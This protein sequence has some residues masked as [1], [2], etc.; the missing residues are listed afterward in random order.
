MNELYVKIIFYIVLLFLGN[1]CF[2]ADRSND[3]VDGEAG[4]V[5]AGVS[6]VTLYQGSM[7][8]Q[9]PNKDSDKDGLS[10]VRESWWL[11]DP[12]DNDTNDDG[13]LDGDSVDFFSE[14]KT[15]PYKDENLKYN[16]VDNDRLPN[17]AEMYDTGTHYR[18][19][20]TDGDP[21][22]DG[23]E[24][25]NMNMPEISPA[26]HP[27]VA[28]YPHLSVRLT[29][30]NVVPKKEIVSTTGGS[31][32]DA[33]SISTES[34]HS[35][36][37]SFEFGFEETVS[38]EYEFGLEGG[39]TIGG[40]FSA[41]QI[42]E[43]GDTWT[44]TKTKSNSG[45]NQEDWST[46]TTTSTTDAA[47]LG[48]GL[49]VQNSGTIPAY[50]VKPDINIKL[51]NKVI[52]TVTL[53]PEIGSI[54]IG[55]ESKEFF[56]D[57]KLVGQ[58]PEEIT[59][60]ME[61][62]RFI[63]AGTPLSIET[64]QVRADVLQWDDSNNRWY[65]MDSSSYINEID[66]R[67][68]TL[69]FELVD[70]DYKEYKVFTAENS[71]MTLGDA[72][73]LTI[74]RDEATQGMNRTWVFGFSEGALREARK[75]L[76]GNESIYNLKLEPGWEI[77]IK[78]K[79][80]NP[81]P[82]I[83]W[84][85]YSQDMKTIFA[86]VTDDLKVKSVAAHV[87]MGG[88]FKDLNMTDYDGDTIYT[89][90]S[91][92]VLKVDAGNYV[93]ATDIENNSA[94]SYI[95][96]SA[97]PDVVTPNQAWHQDIREIQDWAERS[98]GFGS[99]LT[100]GDFDGDGFDDLAV[101]VP[102]DEAVQII[103]GSADGLA[104]KNSTILYLK[105]M[106]YF[107]DSPYSNIITAGGDFDGNGID[108]LAIGEFGFILYDAS[109]YSTGNLNQLDRLDCGV[110][111]SRMAGDF[112]GDGNDDLAVA[113]RTCQPDEEAG[114]KIFSGSKNR[115]AFLSVSST[116]DLLSD[117]GALFWSED[118]TEYLSS[119]PY[120]ALAIGDFDGDGKDDI[121]LGLPSWD[122]RNL[123][124]ESI[125]EDVGSVWIFPGSST[126]FFT[127]NKPQVWYQDLLNLN[128]SPFKRFGHSLA[129]SD[130][131]F[132]GFDDLAIG[133]PGMNISK[134]P[135]LWQDYI[136]RF[137]T[138]GE[139]DMLF[140][141]TR[142]LSASSRMIIQSEMCGLLGY[143]M[144]V[145]DLDADGIDDLAVGEPAMDR[146]RIFFGPIG[147]DITNH[148]QMLSQE[149]LGLNETSEGD[150]FGASLIVGDFN[151]DG[152]DDLAVGAPDKD[153]DIGPAEDPIK[154]AG[155]VYILYGRKR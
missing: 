113:Y 149:S 127:G 121:A 95:N 150:F 144:A 126:G 54:D 123:T 148:S 116:H 64:L 94:V 120:Q 104:A 30:V 98:D 103:L 10:D 83:R 22:G 53:P 2:G 136:Q 82:E 115:A 28:A 68:A 73:N 137:I 91:D 51:G 112:N 29:Q 80:D 133:V 37:S 89:L 88:T 47:R 72:V 23:Q 71:P 76:N 36:T 131:N 142:G 18:R 11:C 21:Y 86:S 33:W 38:A 70:E 101:D 45:W 5:L 111:Y 65:T 49:I 108:D 135:P 107:L 114:L 132:D 100:L 96:A 141:S 69:I 40:E 79:S 9:D 145:G 32:Q 66:R 75:L 102:G 46:A 67:C 106:S 119:N 87:N 31:R 92:Q 128:S 153:I 59:A 25:F 62:L 16:D 24:Y 61:Q 93:K 52:A 84:T 42:W 43:S 57:R 20:S 90:R 8:G 1:P 97:T 19:F 41:H 125:I 3:D 6:G 7:S 109:E 35:A 13:I 55:K 147:G 56:V 134:T 58:T 63:D 85:G 155:A 60:S 48:F 152:I 118:F 129:V 138:P 78:A 151:G 122:K 12:K 81:K 105:S 154:D 117:S 26:D 34:S 124:Y 74:G 77:V 4:E 44:T 99:S 39:L 130:F 14:N 17:R 110:Y 15:W 146:V 27:L 139:V 50:N 143:S 140:G